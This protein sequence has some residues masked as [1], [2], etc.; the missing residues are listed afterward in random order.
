MI[1]TQIQLPE[2]LHEKLKK[3]AERREWSLAE[4]I[5]RAGEV[6]SMRFPEF[7][8][9]AEKWVLPKGRSMGAFKAPV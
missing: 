7:D 9:S 6:Y 4:V 1:R 8:N 5:R 3:I 2:S